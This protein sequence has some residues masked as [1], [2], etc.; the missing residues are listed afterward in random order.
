MTISVIAEFSSLVCVE[1]EAMTDPVV[2]T[3]GCAKS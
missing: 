1:L 3:F 2:R